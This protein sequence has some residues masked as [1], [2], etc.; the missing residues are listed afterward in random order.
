MARIE[1][2]STYVVELTED[3]MVNIRTAL[4]AVACDSETHGDV[5]SV[6]C[7]KLWTVLYEI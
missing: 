2:K 3:E 7:H 6:E 5:L 1:K 4:D